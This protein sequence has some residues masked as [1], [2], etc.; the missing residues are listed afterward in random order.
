[1]KILVTG[2]GGQL[3]TDVAAELKNRKIDFTGVDVI[4]AGSNEILDITDAEAVRRYI[5]IHKPLCVIHCA[6]YT[7]VD[8][9]EDEPELCFIVN[10]TGTEN[11]AKTCRE[12]GTEM[13]YISTDY[14]FGGNENEPYE[15]DAVKNPGSTYGKSKLAG[16]EAVLK[17]LDK[18]YIV[19]IS[20]VF[21]SAGGNFVKTIKRLATEKD[22][23]NV[24]CDQVGSPTYTVDLA[25]LLCDM[26]LSGKYGIY[27]ATN[28]GYCSWAEFATE[29]V[30]QSGVSCII[31][32]IQSE[33]YPTKAK[34]PK[35][36]RLSKAC[37]ERAGFKRLPAWQD[38]LGRFIEQEKHVER[39]R[40]DI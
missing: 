20:W 39:E 24:V 29:I 25:G 4:A 23:I 16:E 35:N 19:R 22:K 37:L 31:N 38:A 32:P 18:Y 12:T 28:E 9:A 10:A 7:A 1:M 11:I 8:K 3:G 30:K 21:G 26:A 34:R 6:A 27:H 5:N 15:T 17:H 14:V 2:A 33:S 40:N 36:S 13:I